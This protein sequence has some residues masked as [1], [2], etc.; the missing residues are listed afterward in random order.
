MKAAIKPETAALQLLM[1]T[2]MAAA[3]GRPTP[4]TTTLPAR[5]APRSRVRTAGNISAS[6]G[7][8]DDLL[9]RPAKFEMVINMKTAK[10]LGLSVPPSS[11]ASAVQV[12]E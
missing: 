2:A 4:P 6:N 10:A 8:L 7:S 5:P 3:T 11:L 12:I 9:H 1:A